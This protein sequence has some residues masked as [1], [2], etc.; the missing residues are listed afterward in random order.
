M[1]TGRDGEIDGVDE[2]VGL[3]VNTVPFRVTLNRSRLA[4]SWLQEIHTQSGAML[5]HG[6]IGLLEIES[7]VKQKPLFQSMLVND[8]S[9]A[10]GM[11]HSSAVG[12][13]G[14]RWVNKGG[15]NEVGYPLTASFTEDG[16]INGMHIQLSGKHGSGYYSSLVAYLNT[17][18]ETLIGESPPADHVT[19]GSL[20][21]QI[22][23][24]ELEHIQTWSQGTC[25]L[26]DG[27]PRLVHDFVLQ[28]KLPSQLNT[29]ALVSLTPPLEFTYCVLI[30]R[31]QLV[32]QRLMALDTP[33][34]FVILFFERSPAFV[35]SM[36]GTLIA[37]KTCV[38]MDATHTSER[39][40][41]MY[42]SLGETQPVVLTSQEYRDTAEKL[43]GDDIICVDDLAQSVV[44]NLVS[45]DWNPP[46][47]TPADVAFVYFTSGSTGKP[48]A[49]PVRHESVVNCIL[50]WC[51]MLNLPPRCRFLQAMNIG[52]DSS[53]FELFTTFHSGGTVVLQ[54]DDLMVS[55]GKVDACVLTPSMLQAVG[56]PAEYPGLRVLV[57]GGEPLPF[58]LAEKWSQT[59]GCQV[60]LFNGY[61]P[62]ETGVTSHFDQVTVT[63]NDRVVTIGRTIPN[64][65]CYILDD[66]LDVVPIGVIGEICIGGVGVCY[67]YLHDEERSRDVFVPNPFAPGML[68]H[69]G[70][71]GCWLPDGR[72]YCM[73]R[74]DNQVKLRG[75]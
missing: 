56:N 25:A 71:L 23:G 50:G 13:E 67:G 29:I 69:T 61:G 40:T 4:Y 48:K 38:P 12:E 2:M 70:D 55:L 73:G 6:H 17:I 66:A 14:L 47:M 58:A 41:G 7:W 57:T 44:G 21:D 42:Q 59:P 34:R 9:R 46:P 65:Q 27:K 74:K 72:V 10:Q 53:L 33:S 5:S 28:G 24:L 36:L 3:T 64:V 54:S 19:V 35:L 11:K 49:V 31:A 32:A 30:T 60:Q 8:K 62:T 22:P 18:L 1:L 51:G 20:L 39:L 75:F 52:F 68:Y 43:F 63:R 45:S 26:Y 16:E 15:Y 37:G